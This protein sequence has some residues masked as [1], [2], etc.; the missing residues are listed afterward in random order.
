M[1]GRILARIGEALFA[2]EAW[3]MAIGRR[4]SIVPAAIQRMAR[5]E[6][7]IPDDLAGKL[8]EETRQRD[9]DLRA[10]LL[11]MGAKPKG[12]WIYD[13]D[14]APK[15]GTRVLLT[16]L[17]PLSSACEIELG[18]WPTMPIY[19]PYPEDP[20]ATPVPIAPQWCR[21]DHQPIFRE[22]I[23]WTPIPR[24]ADRRS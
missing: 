2:T 18:H 4:H 21:H 20:R 9:A 24:P 11:E 7:P 12:A 22:V 19:D 8:A 5:D 10:I 1:T 16:T 3:H 14:A 17:L 6:E 15:D 13:M 23:A